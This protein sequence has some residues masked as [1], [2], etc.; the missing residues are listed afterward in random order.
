[1]KSL[2]RIDRYGRLVLPKANR[3]RLNLNK[4]GLVKI[5]LVGDHIEL[6]P[7]RQTGRILKRVGS[8]LIVEADGNRYNAVTDVTTM[9]ERR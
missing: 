9:R 3:Q 2:V 1:M 5:Q 8:F 6:A 4:G 7:V